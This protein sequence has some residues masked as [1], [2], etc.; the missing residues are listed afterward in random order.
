MVA[1]AAGEAQNPRKNIPTAVQRLFW[2]I[3]FFY[4]LGALAIGDFSFK[5]HEPFEQWFNSFALG[6]RCQPCGYICT[7][8]NSQRRNIDVCI[9]GNAN[10]YAGSR[11]IFAL[12]QDKQA[13]SFLLK[14]SK[15]GVPY[16]AVGITGSRSLLVYLSCSSSST[17]V[18]DW[19]QNSS[20]V[21][22]LFTRCS[23]CVAYSKFYAAVKAQHVDRN[24]LIYKSP[25]QPMAVGT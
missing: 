5:R 23:I 22:R 11:Y 24:S 19:F 9:L 21:S 14:Y 18:S 4:V 10:L 3:L 13:P 8:V 15:A 1:V 25:F 16:Y 7:S 12:A 6:Y 20:T 17:Q 2:R